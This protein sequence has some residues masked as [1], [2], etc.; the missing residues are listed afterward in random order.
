M[1]K[2]NSLKE[3]VPLLTGTNFSQWVRRMG[4][5]L[6]SKD[7]DQVVGF[8]ADTFAPSRSAPTL[9][10]ELK[11]LDRKAKAIIELRLSDS[12][13]V[14]GQAPTTSHAL[15]KSLHQ[16]YQRN[17][18]AALVTAL[19]TLMSTVK[20]PNQSVSEYVAAVQT[21][22]IAVKNAGLAVEE[23]MIVAIVLANV[24]E[25][26]NKVLTALDTLD[27]VP[28]QKAMA[29]LLNAEMQANTDES[30]NVEAN[31]VQALKAE[32]VS[33]KD[34]LKS[35]SRTSSQ[36][37]CSIPYHRHPGG[38][39][40]CFSLHP[41]LRPKNSNKTIQ[42]FVYPLPCALSA[43]S[44]SQD[45]CV[46]ILADSGCSNHM[47]KNYQ[48]FLNYQNVDGPPIELGD[49][50]KIKSKG[51]GSV[52]FKIGDIDF[53]THNVLH[54][55][56]LGKNLFSLG[57][58]TDSGTKYLLDGKYMTIVEYQPDTFVSTYQATSPSQL[59]P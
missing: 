54:V 52:S 33:L 57:Q 20:Q 37:T 17:S 36:S 6:I 7:L 43:R 18:M 1:S 8:D 30:H 42:N 12:I 53:T 16:I 38:D 59:I 9:D 27:D 46:E 34:K 29:M 5:L 58:S 19:K 21:N 35:R 11:K 2:D 31:A 10:V 45:A 32:I 49:N 48:D 4:C 26:Y 51:Q 44:E 56:A 14:L 23:K 15:W 28:L 41:E 50:S 40:A 22:A 13:L 24:P 47:F 39:D 25:D 55:P 3:P